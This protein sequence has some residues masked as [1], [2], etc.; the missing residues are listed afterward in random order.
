MQIK[1]SKPSPK[2]KLFLNDK[3]RYVAFGGARGGGKSWSIRSKAILLATKHKGIRICI[4][5]RTYPELTENHIKPLKKILKCGTKG[6]IAKYNDSKKEMTFKNGSEIIFRYCNSEKDL[7]NFQGTEYDVV[8]FDEATQLKEL[9]VKEI[10]VCVRGANPFPKRTYFTMNPG[11]A[12]H[13]YFKRLF[14]DR[15]FESEEH[16]EDYS[17]IQSLVTDNKILMKKNPG[18]IKQLESLPP[19]LRKA[20]LE[21][22]W[23]VFEGAFFEEFRVSPDPQLCHEAGISEEEA[24]QE[25]R[26]THV[27]KPFKIPDGWKIYRSYDFGFG[28]PFAVNWYAVDY[29]GI[30]Y[31]ILELYGC[32]GTPNEGVKWSPE[33]QF[34]E[35]ARIEREHPYLKGKKIQGVADPSIWDGSRGIAIIE[36]AEK[37]H[38]W[39]EKGINDRIPGWMQIHERLKFDEYGKAMLYI[40][41]NCKDA[42]RTIPLMM[43]DEHKVEDL[44][45]DGEDHICDSLRYFCMARPI[46]PREIKPKEIPLYDPLDQYKKE[47]SSYNRAIFRR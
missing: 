41:E 15:K 25:H 9:W 26:Y 36:E 16:P 1:L 28:K 45:T 46:T 24:L 30:A 12:S 32:T 19:K 33:Q 47:R 44:D 40:F 17:F 20:W 37:Q 38:L 3:H 23:D 8:F 27:I 7:D 34:K 39:F 43:F 22:R 11:G 10:D 29:E 5:R 13:G 2:Q 6:S 21:G 14:I 42:I 18:Y 31:M 35:V 4:I